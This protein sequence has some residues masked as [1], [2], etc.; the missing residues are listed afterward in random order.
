MLMV[1]LLM[2]KLMS[3]K[4]LAEYLDLSQ[5]TIYN[6]ISRGEIPFIKIGGQYRFR[7]DRIDEWLEQ[8]SRKLPETG[9]DKVKQ[10]ADPLTKR[11]LFMGLLT[12]A[13]E[14]QGIKPVVVGGNAVEFYT[15]G[16]YATGDIDIVAPSEP[17]DEVL[18]SW[19]FR[20]EGRH[21]VSQ[22]LDIVIEAP[23]RSLEDQQYERACEV[24]IDALKVYILGIED[25]I[26]DRLNAY[27][28]WKSSDDGVW[29]KEL[30]A[31]HSD[32]I[33]WAYLESRAR[34]E[35]TAGA[36]AELRKELEIR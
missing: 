4:E 5:R 15:A 1:I 25:L 7:Q 27:V 29:V 18:R 13:L 24:E 30:I 21:W 34:K 8:R 28:Y 3:V 32:E 22:E 2:P 16:G 12:K 26:I 11:L 33:D 9:L 19:N 10:T 17:I 36:L 35:G 14:P 20:R 31:L 23:S 6:M